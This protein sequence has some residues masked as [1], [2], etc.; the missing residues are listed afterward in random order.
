M[1]LIKWRLE[2]TSSYVYAPIGLRVI[3]IANR[4]THHVVQ[5]NELIAQAN[6]EWDERNKKAVEDGDE[7]LVYDFTSFASI[8]KGC[9]LLEQ[10]SVAFPAVSAVSVM[11]GSFIDFEVSSI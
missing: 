4:N 3:V 11:Q 7:E 8:C 10:V 2:S 6:R 1:S 9:T 5:V